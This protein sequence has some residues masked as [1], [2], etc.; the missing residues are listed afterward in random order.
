MAYVGTYF[1][2]GSTWILTLM[3]YILIGWYNG[4]LDHYYIDSFKVY[5]AI[6]IVFAAL[7]NT[8]LAILRYRTEQ[9]SLFA[10]LFETFSWIPLLTVFLGGISLHVSQA[11]LCHLCGIDRSWGATSKEASDTSFFAEIPTILKKFRFTF[12]WCFAMTV[13]MIVLSGTGPVGKLV[14]YD[15]QIRAFIA[16][17]PMGTVVFSHCLLPLVLN[18]GLMQ[19]TF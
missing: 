18:P 16:I 8:A 13:G 9:K 4:H 11:I 17:W 15:W 10:A 12:L 2:I 6:V 1:A 19:F 7:G 14:P 3:N 5:F